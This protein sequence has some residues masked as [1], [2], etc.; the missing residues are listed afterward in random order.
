VIFVRRA[1]NSQLSHINKD[2]CRKKGGERKSR[3]KEEEKKGALR[4]K[5]R[6]SNKPNLNLQ[7]LALLVGDIARDK[8]KARKKE[9]KMKRKNK[10]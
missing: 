10:K 9:K 7:Q 4:R 2:R 1:A 5:R 6:E 3:E 8:R